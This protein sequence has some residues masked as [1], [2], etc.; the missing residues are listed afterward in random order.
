MFSR[1]LFTVAGGHGVPFAFS[2][3]R[4]GG[5]GRREAERAK[6]E[7]AKNL[8]KTHLGSSFR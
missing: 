7:K 4:E 5:G 1:D 3:A 6:R 8:Y 2:E